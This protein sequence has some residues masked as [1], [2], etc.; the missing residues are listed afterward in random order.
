G[1]WT[2]P[3]EA[4][5][6]NFWRTHIRKTVQFESGIKTIQSTI[7]N[8]IFV[9]IGLEQ[10]LNLFIQNILNNEAIVVHGFDPINFIHLIRL[11][12][13]KFDNSQSYWPQKSESLINNVNE[14]FEI[15]N[16]HNQ[17]QIQKQET[18]LSIK[19]KVIM[20]FR[21]SLGIDNINEDSDFFEAGGNSLKA[22]NLLALLNKGF[23]K[24]F[25]STN[26]L[27]SSPTPKSLTAFI[28]D[29]LMNIKPIDFIE[30]ET[31][32]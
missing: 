25:N 1:D 18:T 6:T 24:H 10:V 15:Q 19:D 21:M 23:G 11:P 30:N 28:K 22:I 12:T 8:A 26:I 5:T 31:C 27:L 4:F 3:E 17:V 13:Y 2:K 9:E 29:K 14:V 32:S 7:P 20:Y 16:Q